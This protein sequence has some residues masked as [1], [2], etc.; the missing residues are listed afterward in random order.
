MLKDVTFANQL[1]LELAYRQSDYSTIGNVTSYKVAGS[2]APIDW[3]RFRAGFNTAVRAP[4]VGELF[5]PQGEN[6]PG[7]TD[8]CAAEAA[9]SADPAILPRPIR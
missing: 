7:S 1:D 9:G 3:V 6:F 4:S 5:S 2:W 8:P